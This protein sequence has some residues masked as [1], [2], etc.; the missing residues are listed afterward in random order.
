MVDGYIQVPTDGAGKRVDADQITNRDNLTVYRQRVT[1]PDEVSVSSETLAQVLVEQRIQNLLLVQGFGLTGDIDGLRDELSD[2]AGLTIPDVRT[3]LTEDTIF[4]VET[5]GSDTNDGLSV[6]SAFRTV[7]QGIAA[8]QAI[9]CNGFGVTLHIGTGNWSGGGAPFEIRG[10]PQ[11]IWLRDLVIQGNGSANTSISLTI[12]IAGGTELKSITIDP[13]MGDGSIGL[14]IGE[15]AEVIV[16]DTDVVFKAQAGDTD[17]YAYDH[18]SF[19]FNAGYTLSG[20]RTTHFGG[21]FFGRYHALGTYNVACGTTAFTQFFL[22]KE[23]MNVSWEA[24]TSS[25]S[26]TGSKFQITG[27]HAAITGTVAN[28]PGST[29]GTYV[30]DATDAAAP[31][32]MTDTTAA[33]STTTGALTVVGGVGIGGK[34]YI[35]GNTQ[36]TATSIVSLGG[37][38]NGGSVFQLQGTTLNTASMSWFRYSADSA[39]ARIL[40]YKSRN[41]ALGGHTVLQNFDETFSIVGAGSDGS[42]YRDN[43]KIAFEIN[44]TP[45]GGG[46]DNMP[47]AIKFATSPSVGAATTAE[48]MKVTDDVVIQSNVATPAGGSTSA[49]LLFGT[50]AGFGIYYGSG[51]PTVSAA[52]GSLYIRTDNAGASLRLYSNTTGATTWVAITSA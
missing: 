51:A 48:R 23:H 10:D 31:L 33:T 45:T 15:L 21:D 40:T 13:D 25:G 38:P 28:I 5:T 7:T 20:N 1:I 37:A 50:T 22:L 30:A 29:A 39:S 19:S 47:G 3:M 49:R 16:N 46:A 17:I 41:A 52:S 26:P 14:R 2:V 18:G 34:V 8:L 27:T 42:N 24:A 35:G 4:Y 44:G 11:G 6:S 12:R 9:D 32:H 36:L 43:C